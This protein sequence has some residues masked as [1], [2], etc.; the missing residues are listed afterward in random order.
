MERLVRDLLDWSRTQ[1]G[2][3]DPIRTRDADL[4]A[5][6]ERIAD[7]FRERDADRIRVERNGDPRASFD[8]DRME[9]VVGNLLANALRYAPRGTPVVVRAVGTPSEVRLEVH[10]EGPGIPPEAQAQLFEPFR[11]GGTDDAAGIGLGLFI[12]RAVAE[13]HGGN[14]D[15]SSA[16]GRTSFVVRLPREASIPRAH[17]APPP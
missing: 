6:C 9:Q 14:V 17:A 4:H 3:P 7:E 5:V 1:R 2:A 11:R 10:D 13:A 15:V 8:P 12:V 16:P